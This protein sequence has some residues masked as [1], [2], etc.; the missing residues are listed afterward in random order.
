MITFDFNSDKI[1]GPLDEKVFKKAVS[2]LDNVL[3]LKKKNNFSLAIVD[4]STIRKWN[5]IYRHKDKVTDVLSFAE[6]DQNDFIDG[7]SD[8]KYLGEVLI[9][10]GQ[11]KR[12]A[13]ELEHSLEAELSRLVIHGVAHLLGYDHE[14]VP[15]IE[16]QKMVE[17]E[18]KAMKRLK[19][20]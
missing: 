19:L 3:N 7:S 20:K 10:Y 12:Q 5:R 8:G 18:E 9:C 6:D 14:K 2:A 15:K 1:S 4:G 13:R 16:A 11:A 17:I